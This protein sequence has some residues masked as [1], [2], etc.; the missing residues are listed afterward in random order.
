MI[1][2]EVCHSLQCRYMCD[3][4]DKILLGD[5][6]VAHLQSVDTSTEVTVDG[7]KRTMC[8]AI[9]CYENGKNL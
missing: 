2:A 6:M 7:S 5:V 8:K 1:I 4:G 9:L 3:S